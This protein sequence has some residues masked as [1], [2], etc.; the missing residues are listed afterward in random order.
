MSHLIDKSMPGEFVGILLHNHQAC[1]GEDRGLAPLAAATDL[2][3]DGSVAL[4][5]C[6]WPQRIDSDASE[7][8]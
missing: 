1:V 4:Y 6:S 3:V 8:V 7:I 2:E 5:Q